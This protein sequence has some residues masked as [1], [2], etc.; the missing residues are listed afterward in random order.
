[1]A[2][3]PLPIH[4]L[5][6]YGADLMDKAYIKERI[7]EAK[8]FKCELPYKNDRPPWD[9]IAS[10][11]DLTYVIMIETIMNDKIMQSTDE[12]LHE[13]INT[14]KQYNHIPII[15]EFYPYENDRYVTK[16]ADDNTIVHI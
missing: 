14:A 8:K 3:I 1:M 5:S 12:R 10:K 13:F 2:D 15:L 9:L 16:Y 4:Y 6:S 11:G 7:F